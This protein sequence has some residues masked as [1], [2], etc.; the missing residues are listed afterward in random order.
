MSQTLSPL[1]GGCAGSSGGNGTNLGRGGGAIQ[2][3]ARGAV[4][5][6]G[7]ILA[8]GGP[9]T[10]A[11]T[12]GA[13]GGGGGS[14]GAILIE[15]TAVAFGANALLAANGGSGS[16]GT[17]TNVPSRPGSYGSFDV[18]TVAGGMPGSQCG[19]LGGVG[20]ARNGGATSGGEGGIG[21]CMINN[22]GGGGG[23]GGS[24]GR[25]RVNSRTPCVVTTGA[26]FS[27]PSTSGQGSCAR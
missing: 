27:P 10:V 22:Y 19:G 8:A 3:W 9:G 25:V 7:R 21:S 14:G 26:R 15:G 1:R 6:T 24:V 13:G 17:G 2:L 20:A 18:T 11:P 23:G 12:Y 16:Q 4:N 5:I